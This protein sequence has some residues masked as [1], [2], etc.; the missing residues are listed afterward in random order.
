LTG[1]AA[2]KATAKAGKKATKTTASAVNL[3]TGTTKA[4]K[5]AT[6]K[7]STGK[8]TKGNANNTPGTTALD[9]ETIALI[10]ELTGIKITRTLDEREVELEARKKNSETADAAV[11]L[12]FYN[13]CA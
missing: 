5:N 8:A 12:T 10:E 1:D 4:A 6:E 7:A 13:S 11:R 3:S 9:A 2:T